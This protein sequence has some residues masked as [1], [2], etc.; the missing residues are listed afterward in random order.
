MSNVLI[1][2]FSLA[3]LS[4]IFIVLGVV[5]HI[6]GAQL[7]NYGKASVVSILA[8]LVVRFIYDVTVM[9]TPKSDNEFYVAV[10]GGGLTMLIFNT[11]CER[12]KIS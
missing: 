6:P 5:L 1:I 8:I 3:I 7:K 9:A 2:I 4:V 12:K 10:I 11:I